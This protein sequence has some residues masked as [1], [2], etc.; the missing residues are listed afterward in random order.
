MSEQVPYAPAGASPFTAAEFADNPEPRCP[1]ALILD[2]SGSMSGQPIQELNQ[3]LVAFKDELMA[4]PLAAKRVE[5][6]I[7]T[8]GPIQVVADFQTADLFQPPTLSPQGDTPLGGAV[9]QTLEMVRQ[10]KDLLRSNGIAIYRPWIFLITD[11]GP[12]DGNVWRTAA[13][14]IREGE[15][16]KGFAFFAVG[17]EGAN[18]DVLK[19][20]AVRDPLRLQGLKFRQLFQWLSSSM[21]SVSRSTPGDQVP[22]ENPAGPTGW[23]SV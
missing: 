3:G 23:A 15:E 4:D 21:K 6:A 8:F 17:V 22:I 18:M 1:C 11:G 13:E 5:V 10:R 16:Q 19:E 12:T 9:L 20:L 2:V 7:V 14:R